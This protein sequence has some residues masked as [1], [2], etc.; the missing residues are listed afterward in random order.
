MNI[1]MNRTHI[2]D[3][4]AVLDAIDAPE[5]IKSELAKM[6][7]TPVNSIRLLDYNTVLHF[8]SGKALLACTKKQK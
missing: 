6:V 5:Y 8:D 3:I 4:T 2:I 7:D 1:N